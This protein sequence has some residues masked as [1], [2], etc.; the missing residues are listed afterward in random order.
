MQ[1]IQLLIAVSAVIGVT[2]AHVDPNLPSKQSDEV[3]DILNVVVMDAKSQVEKEIMENSIK[4]LIKDITEVAKS[5]IRVFNKNKKIFDKVAAIFEEAEGMKDSGGDVA[6]VELLQ[7][8][9]LIKVQ[10]VLLQDDG[11]ADNSLLLSAGQL[12]LLE[13]G[14]ANTTL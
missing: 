12:S 14:I 6:S 5:A 3:E 9:L 13:T 10:E 11:S 8:T 7:T 1:V 2:V 4:E